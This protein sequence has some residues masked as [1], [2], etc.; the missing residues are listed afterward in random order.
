M[1]DES[2]IPMTEYSLYLESGPRRR[3]TMV[4]VLG[5]LGCIANGPT[6]EEALAAT[7][8]AIR[9]YLRFL[10]GCGEAVDPQAA[11]TTVIAAHVMEGNWL[12]NGDPTPGF[13]PDFLPLEAA[14][15]A[16]YLGRL[17]A[18]LDAGLA[19]IQGLSAAQRAADPAGG[20]RPVDAILRHMAGSQGVYLRYLVGK[21]DG[22]SETLKAADEVD[23]GALPLVLTRLWGICRK[24]LEVLTPEER[25]RRVPHGEVVWTARRALRRMLEHPWE[26]LQEISRRIE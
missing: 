8:D 18:L 7:P 2:G 6:T 16:A 15:L 9:A 25:T 20:G 10:Q 17:D 24:R 3:K 5:L 22:L 4:H 19:R 12:A 11:F 14:D 23:P 13:A 21:V 1:I 26:H